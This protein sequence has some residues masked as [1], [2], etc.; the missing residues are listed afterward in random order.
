MNRNLYFWRRGD[1]VFKRR[2]KRGLKNM[3]FLTIFLIFLSLLYYFSGQIIS[4]PQKWEL[5]R[6][7]EIKVHA[8][9]QE[10]KEEVKEH[11]S[12]PNLQSVLSFNSDRIKK[13]IM[14][15]P[16][17]RDL[18][19]KKVL[20]STIEIFV[21]EREEVAIVKSFEKFVIDE[22]GE[23]IKKVDG[24]ISLPLITGA[25]LEEK[26]KISIALSLINDLKR[27]GK[28]EFVEEI[29]LSNPLNVGIK[30]KGSET[31]VFLGESDH[32]SKF[33][34]YLVMEKYLRKEFGRIEY[35]GFYDSE[36]VYIKTFEGKDKPSMDIFK[37]GGLK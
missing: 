18:K 21:E 17:V 26:E 34:R 23:A 10:I 8:K 4:C 31:K 27:K 1:R 32:I 15:N 14:R 20:P 25:T 7:K 13:L 19:I 33:E 29:D 28:L 30:L 36:R 35:V 22:K 37:I 12:N 3:I 16:Y 6:V 24:E 5:F 9:R 2:R 11:F